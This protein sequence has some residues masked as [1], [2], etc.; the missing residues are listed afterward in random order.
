MKLLRICIGAWTLLSPFAT[1]A[2]A[3]TVLSTAFPALVHEAALVVVGTAQAIEAEWNEATETPYT[4]VTFTDLDVL[5]GSHSH[6]T[7][8]IRLL[9]G[10]APDGTSLQIAGVPAFSL[11]ERSILFV[12]GNHH[13]AIPF[14]GLW[15]GVFR[16]VPDPARD[17]ETVYT[18]DM[19][20]LTSLP[21]SE[22]ELL[23]DGSSVQALRQAAAS[24]MT[25]DDFA[26]AVEQE[27]AHD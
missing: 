23:H 14:V 15:Q 3:T 25:L 4:L 26:A 10:A 24:P 11:G 19:Q 27:A 13:Y 1:S 18:H 2:H 20:P 6:P 16:V 22:G 21:G 8:T 5:K 9:G 17:T 12:T 7:L